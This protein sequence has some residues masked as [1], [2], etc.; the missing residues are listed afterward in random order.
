MVDRWIGR[1]LERIGSLGL[2]ESTAIIFA[3][4]HGFYFGEHGQFGKARQRS[5][6]GFRVGTPAGGAALGGRGIF[7]DPV[8]GRTTIATSQWYRSPLYEE[9][10]RVPLLMYL[11]QARP[12]RIDALVSS[13]D[14]M[15]TILE[16]ADLEI[17]KAVQ[18]SSLTPLL[19]GKRDQVHDFIVTSWPLYN[20]GQRIRV[21]DDWE[22]R[23]VEP[24][25]STIT[26]GEWTLIYATEGEP[27]ELYH[28]VS[29]P[30]QQEN[31]FEGNEAVARDLHAKFVGFL[32]ELGTD[33]I[34]LAPRRRLL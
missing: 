14:L 5:E 31:V 30:G 12:A 9:V 34:F 15:P 25:P 28:T 10:T 26:D 22:R 27:V 1:L 23:L 20:L 8:T 32:E 21:V 4:D 17:P 6:H 3:S 33:E 29:D 19:R 18:A 16:L 2:M 13:P 24:L 11:P 7:R